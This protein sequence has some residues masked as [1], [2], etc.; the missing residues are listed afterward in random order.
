MFK[1]DL[2]LKISTEKTNLKEIEVL[3]IIPNVRLI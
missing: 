2:F 1:E 3:D